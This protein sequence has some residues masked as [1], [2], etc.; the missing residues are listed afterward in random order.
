[1]RAL[2]EDHPL[3]Y[4]FDDHDAGEDNCNGKSFSLKEVNSAYRAVFPH[5]PL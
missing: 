5:Y 2:Y 4:T 1:M 3:V